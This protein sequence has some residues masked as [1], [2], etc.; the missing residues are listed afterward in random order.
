MLVFGKEFFD[1]YLFDC[2]LAREN[3]RKYLRLD[4]RVFLC[5]K[6]VKSISK[7]KSSL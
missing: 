6:N 5:I 1:R 2:C 7:P 4:L 3:N